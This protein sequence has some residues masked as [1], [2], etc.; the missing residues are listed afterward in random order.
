[1]FQGK[2]ASRQAKHISLQV[3]VRNRRV[4]GGR[5]AAWIKLNLYCL[6]RSKP[7]GAC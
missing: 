4:R 1:M 2:R 7:A 5:I 6:K 3:P